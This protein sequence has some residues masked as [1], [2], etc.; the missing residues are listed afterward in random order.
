MRYLLLLSFFI[1]A[2]LVSGQEDTVRLSGIEILGDPIKPFIIGNSNKS[3]GLNED[4]KSLSEVLSGKGNIYF[5]SYGN[6]QLSTITMRGTSANQTNV[7]WHGIP[8]NYP[9]L[10]LMDFSQWPAWFISSLDLQAGSGGAL[11]GSGSIGGTVLLDSNDD[12]SDLKPGATARIDVG[13]FG[14]SFLGVKGSYRMGSIIA[15]T[16]LFRKHIENDFTYSHN[17]AE[18]RQ[19]NASSSDIGIQQE[20][21]WNSKNHMFLLDGMVTKNDREVQP[22]DGVIN[23]DELVTSNVRVSL[24]HRYTSLAGSLHSTLAYVR[25][26]TLY[27]D[28][29]ETIANQY[30][31]LS[32]YLFEIGES[33]SS[34][35]GFNSN[36]YQ[37]TSANFI[38]NLYDV[39]T[40]IFGSLSAEFTKFW[41]GSVSLRQSIFKDNYP[42]NPAFNQQIELYKN[43]QQSLILNQSISTGFRFP[44]LN[45][46]YWSPGGNAE[47]KPEKSLNTDL[48]ITWNLTGDRW[49]LQ[50]SSSA[51]QIWS[52]DYIL[53]RPVESG[54][55]S[56]ENFQEVNI[57]G[58]EAEMILKFESGG[59]TESITTAYS[60]TESL[61][62]TGG[63]AGNQLPYVPKNQANV[64]AQTR[65]TVWNLHLSGSW[66]SRRYTTLDQSLAHSV[67]GFFLMD[68]RFTREITL[69]D[70]KVSFG[71]AI[72][73]LFDTDYQNLINHSMPGRNY[74][75]SLMIKQ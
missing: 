65:W 73:N 19:N 43:S 41:K 42:L 68:M 74:Q 17:G 16:K 71:A 72:N 47:L 3:I 15:S 12:L 1:Y 22:A 75:L 66:T 44:T 20:L 4:G 34:R 7:L 67:E 21:Q 8:V 69:K 54:I 29:L 60:V 28:S 53:W 18:W 6:Q 57:K 26:G 45:D 46:L 48:G 25:N 56:P 59:F 30:S 5:K 14:Y 35:I 2:L 37:A 55:W 32:A 24:S 40:G 31:F 36:I 9:T 10:G 58:I 23:D 49:S 51:F 11:F 62:E 33:M 63:N 39:R 64:S 61:N 27:N 13:S 50:A 38:D 70:W 52:R